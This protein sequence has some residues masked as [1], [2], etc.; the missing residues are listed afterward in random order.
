[1]HLFKKQRGKMNNADISRS[2]K[3]LFI[4]K[5]ILFVAK[6]DTPSR[7]VELASLRS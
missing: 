1:M 7:R 3:A 6:E 5:N 4:T 2:V